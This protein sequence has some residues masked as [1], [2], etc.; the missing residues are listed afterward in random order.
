MFWIVEKIATHLNG[1]ISV[2]DHAG[3]A[4]ECHPLGEMSHMQ[5][6]VLHEKTAFA[7]KLLGGGSPGTRRRIN[8]SGGM[9]AFRASPG[10][11]S[12]VLTAMELASSQKMLRM[13]TWSKS[14]NRQERKRKCEKRL[15]V[16]TTRRGDGGGHLS[17]EDNDCIVY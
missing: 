15:S 10:G 14:W 13:K 6:G 1:K 11:D 8:T 17:N 3:A 7:P 2:D 9:S 5:L 4:K 12:S 16:C